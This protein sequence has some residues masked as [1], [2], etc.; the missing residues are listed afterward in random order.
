MRAT[1]RIVRMPR[2]IS[3]RA[4]HNGTQRA[5]M[6]SELRDAVRAATGR[7]D[8][9]RAVSAVYLTLADEIAIRRPICKTSGRCCRFEEFG[10]RLYV[11]TMELAKFS[12]ELASD[13]EPP[14]A[15]RDGS[16]KPSLSH[17]LPILTT[18]NLPS[19]DR[20]PA[21]QP[22]G[23]PFQIQGL[24]GVHALRPFGCR[25][26]FCDQTSTAWQQDLYERLHGQIRHLHDELLVPYYY[27]EWRYALRALGLA[28]QRIML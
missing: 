13:H 2:A 20:Q 8:V 23:C 5:T 12:R 28:K 22:P 17:R 15:V 25:I 21:D 6:E 18:D 4:G 24:C 10:H 3:S 16:L 19:A 7:D 27:V 1:A 14:S 11:T 9:C 26:F